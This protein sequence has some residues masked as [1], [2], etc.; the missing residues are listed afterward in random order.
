MISYV[1][2]SGSYVRVYDENKNQIGG[3]E[4][5]QAE[6]VVSWNSDTVTTREGSCVRIYTADGHYR[7]V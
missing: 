7:T 1:E 4:L 3:F 5:N 2:K 6:E